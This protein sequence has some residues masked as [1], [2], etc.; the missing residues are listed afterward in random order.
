[1]TGLAHLVPNAYGPWTFGSQL[2]GPSG[3]TVPNQFSPHGKMVPQNLVPMDKWS[4][5]NLVPLD[6][7]SLEYSPCPGGQAVGIQKYGDQIGW[8]TICP[9]EP[10]VQG[11]QIFGDHLSRGTKFLGTICPWGPNLMGIVCP[12]G[13]ILWGSFVQGD[14]KWGT[15]SPEIKWVR[16]QMCC[17]H[18]FYDRL[19]LNYEIFY[20]IKVGPNFVGWFFS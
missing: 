14:R 10:F 18:N 19:V 3:Q 6:K 8:G 7:W 9:G 5:A 4:P 2:I 13:S 16:D 17:S 20:L 1:M 15:G 11:D 12:G